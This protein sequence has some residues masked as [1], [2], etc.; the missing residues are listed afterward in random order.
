VSSA[1]QGLEYTVCCCVQA[2][3][4]DSTYT[5]GSGAMLLN[6]QISLKE[7]YSAALHSAVGG[8]LI[9]FKLRDFLGLP[10]CNAS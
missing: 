4:V 9:L 10:A 3:T 7:Q 8:K 6:Q 2:C 1:Q 5:D